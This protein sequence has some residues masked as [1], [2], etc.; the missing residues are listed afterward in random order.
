MVSRY[1]DL[2]FLD[3]N[4]FSNKNLADWSMEGEIHSLVKSGQLKGFEIQV[5]LHRPY[6]W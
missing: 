4:L 5:K 2:K 3:V 1:L 6:T